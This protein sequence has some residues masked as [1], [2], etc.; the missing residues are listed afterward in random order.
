MVSVLV[1]TS[2]RSQALGGSAQLSQ[3]I[4]WV[5]YHAQ[6]SCWEETSVMSGFTAGEAEA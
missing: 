2:F 3:L 4:L 6:T 5:S 1:R